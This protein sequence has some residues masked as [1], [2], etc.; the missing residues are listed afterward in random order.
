MLPFNRPYISGKEATYLAEAMESGRLEGDGPFTQRCQDWLRRWSG[1]EAVLLTHSCTAAL[2][3]AALLLELK[4]GDEVIMPSYTFVSTANAFA[5]RGAVPVFVDI[6]ADTLNLDERVVDAAV[7]PRTRAIVAVH[8]AGVACEM[9]VLAQVA[10]RHGLMLIEDAA[11][12]LL[13]SYHGRPLGAIGQLGAISFHATKNVVSGE[14]GALL[15][16]DASLTERAE[17]I[18][19]KGTD[20]KRFLRG[21]VDKYTWQALGSSFLPSELTAAFL[22]AQ[23]D[24]AETIT[25]GRMRIW[26]R[27]HEELEPLERAGVLTR[28][29]IPSGCAHNAHMYYICLGQGLIREQFIKALRELGIQA[30]SHYEPLHNS[31]AGRRFG[32]SVGSLSV[33]ED[34]SG[35]IVRLPLWMG[36][37]DADVEQ[38]VGSVRMAVGKV[39]SVRA[40]R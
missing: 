7:S 2:E 1:A 26:Q 24:V 15:I 17:V 38:V 10:Q 25:A 37:Q 28:P 36:L 22:A 32:R 23:L 3:L 18:R 34:L 40:V 31:P 13:A 30:A 9:D 14:G 29:S 20:R 4:S 11:Q 19:E 16:N 5:L 39:G 35:R 8:Y 27:Y 33:T 21:E 6:R 12:G